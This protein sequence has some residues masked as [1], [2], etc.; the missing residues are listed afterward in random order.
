[1][2]ELEA[3][4]F[5]GEDH[6][7][8]AD[9]IAAAERRE[10]DIGA[11]TGTGVAIAH[12]LAAA[13]EIDAAAPRGGAAQGQRRARGRIDLVAVMHL[14]HFDVV[15]FIE[16]ARRLLDQRLQQGH[17]R[18]HIRCPDDRRPARSCLDRL[19]LLSIETGGADDERLAA[20]RRMSGMGDGGR[21]HGEID[22][23]VRR[24]EERG[25]VGGGGD[26]DRPDAGE[27]AD[28]AAKRRA[29]RRL[30]TAGEPQ[31]RC[32]LR[33]GDEHAPHPAGAAGDADADLSH[34]MIAPLLAFPSA[35]SLASRPANDKRRAMAPP[36][37][38]L[39]TLGPMALLRSVAT[40]GGYTMISRVLGFLREMLTATF[41]GAGPLADAFF[42]ALRLPNMFRSLFAEGAF[43]AAFVPL[44]A[45]KLAE[46]GRPAARRFAEEALAVLLVA[47][48]LFLVAGEILTPWILDVLAP[49]FR[50]DPE[51]FANAVDLTRIMF[52]YLLFISLTALEGGVLNSLE[53]FAATAA[54][55]VLL[56]I[57]LIAVLLGV[58][59]LTGT[60]LAW[61]VT[62]A[63]FA[64]F[65]WLM[66]SCARAGLPLALPRPRLTPEVRRLLRLM[67]PGAFGAG[68]VQ[69]NLLVSTAMASF[70]P[71][72][73]VAYL[74]YADRLN[75]LPLAVVG[76]AVGTAILPP[77]SRH[78]RSGDTA[79]AIETQNR[80]IELA[81]LLALPAAVGLA[82][83][84][85]PILAVLFQHGKFTAADT[86]AT[87]PALAAYALGLPAFVL[88]KVLV[89]G[90]LAR[91][92]TKT[93]VQIAAIAMIVN[94][95]LTVALGVTLAQLGVAL[96]LTV[97]GWVN[98]LLL[99]MLLH[100]RRL[101][102]FD[103]HARR[104][105]PRV[106]VAALGMGA[107][108]L[109]LEYA[110]AATL[111]GPFL[112]QVAALALLVAAG[113]AGFALLVVALGVVEWREIARRFRRRA[114]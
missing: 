26:A 62:A 43:N 75:Q 12:A 87:A 45:G 83:A 108:V 11:G 36:G 78:V 8:V 104:A 1:V 68:V 40:V 46:E 22:D 95:T 20:P 21:G 48:L 44:F 32:G 63:G 92:D 94:V 47:L 23:D 74:N 71:T 72:G 7:V 61:A 33:L 54:T 5:A 56:N 55:P 15:G 67:L 98:A 29:A 16:A 86:A 38:F 19:R 57:F 9:D 79:R 42:V 90:F 82:A 30:V 97:A 113:L 93:P 80:A 88:V 66:F 69:I 51:K 106:A 105:L 91:Q 70:L 101:F 112:W 77:L 107:L 85:Q 52:P 24:G 76:F 3:L 111:R 10:A 96:A 2:G 110:L 34:K 18:A 6:D 53:R 58:R 84:A 31:A 17:G 28:V 41:L 109:G 59:P 50:N 13:I 89:P 27:L 65:V 102:A 35:Q 73:T 49:G 103:P 81:L 39:Y 114:A 100:R 60:A 4:A 99:L 64:Q 14:Q 37:E 25:K